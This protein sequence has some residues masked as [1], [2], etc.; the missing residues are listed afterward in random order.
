MNVEWYPVLCDKEKDI[1]FGKSW[2]HPVLVPDLLPTD[3]CYRKI[4]D[5]IDR[6]EII[7]DDYYGFMNDDNC[8]EPG[9]FDVVRQQT[10]KILIYS[11]YRGDA[12]PYVPRDRHAATTLQINKLEDVKA[13]HIDLCQMIVKGSIFK[14]YRF[15]NTSGYGD[16]WYAERLVKNHPNDITV[17]PNLY[18][19]F[20]FFQPGRFTDKTKF[21]KSTWELPVYK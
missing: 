18:A 20:N 6:R 9:F 8:Y 19:F 7:D 5:F 16:G 4:N 10:S 12:S 21:L 15:D 13:G 2:V 11:A 17:I 1:D 14:Q 3:Q